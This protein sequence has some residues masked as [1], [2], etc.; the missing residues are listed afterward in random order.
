LAKHVAVHCDYKLIPAYFSAYVCTVTVKIVLAYRA[1]RSDHLD[2]A[3]TDWI[4]DKN[5]KHSARRKKK[6]VAEHK[7]RGRN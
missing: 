3:E 2:R 5:L 4:A 7:K 1:V 6:T